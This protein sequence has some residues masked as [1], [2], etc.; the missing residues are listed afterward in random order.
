MKKAKKRC[1]ENQVTCSKTPPTG[2]LK[3]QETQ[4]Q[5]CLQ[6]MIIPKSLREMKDTRK[7]LL[8]ETDFLTACFQNYRSHSWAVRETYRKW[9]MNIDL[10]KSGSPNS[11]NSKPRIM[12]DKPNLKIKKLQVWLTQQSRWLE[13]TMAIKIRNS[14]S[15]HLF[16]SRLKTKFHQNLDLAKNKQA[17]TWLKSKWTWL[18]SR[19]C[20]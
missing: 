12:T 16:K 1:P 18:N 17:K 6:P 20:H 11:F 15:H 3:P 7:I 13:V 10:Q 14:Y 5:V 19:T 2:T 4:M 8:L 9:R